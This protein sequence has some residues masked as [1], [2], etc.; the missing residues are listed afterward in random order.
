[1]DGVTADRTRRGRSVG[2]ENK[3]EVGFRDV[4][5]ARS[6]G[7]PSREVKQAA[8]KPG[9]ERDRGGGYGSHHQTDGN[10]YHPSS[11]LR[12]SAVRAQSCWHSNV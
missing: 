3:S 2:L 5:F 9:R 7:Q 1:M 8:E 10:D 4:L 12:W 11:E 6:R